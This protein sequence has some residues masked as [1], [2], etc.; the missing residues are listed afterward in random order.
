M[1]QPDE[2]IQHMY[3]V[4][5]SNERPTSK[6]IEEAKQLNEEK[7]NDYAHDD[8]FI[9]YDK[10]ELK[11]AQRKMEKRLNRYKSKSKNPENTTK[12]DINSKSAENTIQPQIKGIHKQRENSVLRMKTRSQRKTRLVNNSGKNVESLSLMYAF[13]EEGEDSSQSRSVRKKRLEDEDYTPSISNEESK[14]ISKSRQLQYKNIREQQAKV[15]SNLNIIEESP[16]LTAS[17]SEVKNAI[18]QDEEFMNMKD[19]DS[20]I[21]EIEVNPNELLEWL[22][23]H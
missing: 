22:S 23:Q 9:V 21:D 4:Y 15:E 17:N 8:G 11:Q 3:P 14:Y 16:I 7:K 2:G 10:D 5:Q 13:D 20:K 6:R 18:E 1:L 19:S 12:Q